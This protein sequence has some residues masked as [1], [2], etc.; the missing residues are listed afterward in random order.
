MTGRPY[1]YGEKLIPK[2]FR[3]PKSMIAQVVDFIDKLKADR[4]QE[5]KQSK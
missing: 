4:E 2:T 3:I 5:I 1:K